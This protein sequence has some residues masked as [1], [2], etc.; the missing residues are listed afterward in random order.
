MNGKLFT[1]DLNGDVTAQLQDI[2]G[3]IAAILKLRLTI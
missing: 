1:V 2:F 3:Q